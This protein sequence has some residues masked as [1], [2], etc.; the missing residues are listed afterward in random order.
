M[1]LL[2]FTILKVIFKN[3][4][5]F[6]KLFRISLYATEYISPLNDSNS[7]SKNRNLI[8]CPLKYVRSLLD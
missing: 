7:D 1:T 2:L 6:L 5:T 8:F 4:G 3:K